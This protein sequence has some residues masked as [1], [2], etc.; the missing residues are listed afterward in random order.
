MKR[1]PR[2]ILVAILVVVLS[3]PAMASTVLVAPTADVQ[4][5]G[6]ME[7]DFVHHRGVNTVRAQFGIFPGISLGLRQSLN[8]S[9]YATLKGAIFEESNERPGFAIGG[10]LSLEQQHLY[11]VVSKQLGTPS[12]RGHVALGSGRY[13]RAMAGIT[14]MLNPVK[15]S[16]VPTTSVFMEY[17]GQGLNGGM[18]AQFSPELKA[19][20][21]LAI[22]HGLSFGLNYKVTF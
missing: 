7:M 20:V 18:I 11:A 13:S 12:L 16:N 19:N 15:T 6:S 10:E 17:D 4:G 9:L 8:G 5:Q 2:A 1:M 14:L 3:V 21:G 22:G